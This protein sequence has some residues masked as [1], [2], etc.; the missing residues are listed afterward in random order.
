MDQT[1]EDKKTK[2]LEYLIKQRRLQAE[3]GFEER[4]FSLNKSLDYSS[5]KRFK[6][7]K[8]F[9]YDPYS[10]NPLPITLKN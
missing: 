6:N 1:P 2:L 8:D 7:K 5:G 9:S 10:N 3:D 4:D